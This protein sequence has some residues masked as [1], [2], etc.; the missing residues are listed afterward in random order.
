MAISAEQGMKT[1]KE[2]LKTPKKEWLTKAIDYCKGSIM[3][4]RQFA[5]A[6]DHPICHETFDMFYMS[7]KDGY[8]VYLSKDVIEWFGYSGI[9]KRQ[10]QNIMEILR[11]NYI[12]NVDWFEYSQSIYTKMY[13]DMNAMHGQPCI[14][15]KVAV[16]KEY[17]DVFTK[18][19]EPYLLP[20]PG[21]ANK[22]NHIIINAKIFKKVVMRSD[23]PKA[24][25]IRNYYVNLEEIMYKYTDYID[26]MRMSAGLGLLE[27][28]DQLNLTMVENNKKADAERK[29]AEEER[30]KADEYRKKSR[31]NRKKVNEERKQAEE[32]RRQAEAKHEEERKQAEDRFN[33]LMNRTAHVQDT[34][35]TT[36]VVLTR[37]AEEHVPKTHVHPSKYEVLIILRDPDDEEVPYYVIR[38]QQV[39]ANE[40]VRKIK[41]DV[42]DAIEVARHNHPNSKKLWQDFKGQYGKHL[43]STNSNWFGISPRKNEDW[44]VERLD[45]MCNSRRRVNN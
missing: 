8:P 27:K 20:P 38:T 22:N 34:L 31:A 23:S 17:I 28:L 24:E 16:S 37:V 43:V 7:L 32:E 18:T 29:Q 19:T 11:A 15:N 14:E 42:P 10:K 40:R 30:K 39:S 36:N 45:N 35:D 13:S 2:S 25:T 41:D 4:I 44:F 3:D 9:L 21:N 26:E 5:N 12:Q 1:L 6:I 33:Q